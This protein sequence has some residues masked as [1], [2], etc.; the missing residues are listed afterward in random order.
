MR[1]LVLL[2]AVVLLGGCSI[3]GGDESGSVK[4]DQLKDLVLQPEDV[5]RVFVRFDEGRLGNTEMPGG[6]RTQQD[7]FGRQ[8]GWKARYRRT[9]TRQTKG[10]LVIVSLVD[11]FESTG[12]AKEEYEALQADLREGELNW[13]PVDAPPLGDD[14]LAMGLAQGSGQTSVSFFLIAWR[15][16]NVVASVEAS[17]FGDRIALD[18]AVSLA[19]KQAQRIARAA[20]A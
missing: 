11:V 4:P 15:E 9:G 20:D 10:P 8:E 17:G 19:R 1:P 16:G 13:Q 7:R 12:G 14:A 5:P 3:G 18:D 2:F 6:R